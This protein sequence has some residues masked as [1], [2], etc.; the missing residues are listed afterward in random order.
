[1]SDKKHTILVV[2]DDED[3]LLQQK[4]QLESAGF[5]VHTAGTPRKGQEL[6]A[7]T[8]PD[9]AILDLMMGDMDA[10][11]GLCHAMKKARPDLPVILVTSVMRETGL[12]LDVTTDEERSWIQ[13]DVVLDKPVRFEQLRRE[14]GRLLKD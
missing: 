13:A 4:V 5:T 10:G 7:Q 1:M 12:E 8:K 11:L 2:D 6:F 9:L 3:F 14:I